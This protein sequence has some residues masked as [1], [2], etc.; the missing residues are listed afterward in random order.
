MTEKEETELA[1]I[2]QRAYSA[3]QTIAETDLRRVAFDRLLEFLLTN[4]ELREMTLDAQASREKPAKQRGKPKTN[5]RRPIEG[6]SSW[7]ESMVDEGFFATPKGI[8]SVVERVSAMGHS[9][10]SKDVTFPLV[11]LVQRKRLR[12]E[13]GS[14]GKTKRPVWIY[15]NY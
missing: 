5:P 1:S 3:T 4:S 6:P 10:Q 7:V 15:T 13:R 9:V 12:R 2:V 8:A 14:D 11:Q